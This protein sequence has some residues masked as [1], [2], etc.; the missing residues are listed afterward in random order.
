[1]SRK[2]TRPSASSPS[3]RKR[4]QATR[5]RDTTCELDLRRELTAL[6]L[7]YRIERAVP[8]S[9]RRMDVVFPSLR[10]GVFVDGCFWHS[11]PVHG[12]WPKANAEWWR[13]K[14]LGNVTRDRDTDARLK[15]LGW[16]VIRVWE[17][18]E[19]SKAASKIL[20]AVSRRRALDLR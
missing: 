2:T 14:I 16:T 5:R 8:G 10:I 13:A 4:M 7:R 20:R 9:R 19:P 18:E 15:A 17:H 11:C 3:V 1:M 12:T 6:G